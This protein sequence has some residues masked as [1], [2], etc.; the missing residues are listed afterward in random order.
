[1]W[2]VARKWTL[3]WKMVSSFRISFCRLNL[4]KVG[5]ANACR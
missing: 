2:L 4:A 5:K 3:R 1:L